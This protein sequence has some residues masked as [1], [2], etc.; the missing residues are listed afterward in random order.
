MEAKDRGEG[1]F[2]SPGHDELLLADRLNQRRRG[3]ELQVNQQIESMLYLHPAHGGTQR[4]LLLDLLVVLLHH[5][6]AILLDLEP[7]GAQR[8]ERFRAR[9]VYRVGIA[10]QQIDGA[11]ADDHH[12]LLVVSVDRPEDVGVGLVEIQ[13]QLDMWNRAKQPLREF[14][15]DQIDAAEGWSSIYTILNYRGVDT[16]EPEMLIRGDVDMVTLIPA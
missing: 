5:L 1:K 15:F 13:S 10:L 14:M 11:I 8:P 16:S 9:E 6:D 2:P 3:S 4:D 12:F 7:L